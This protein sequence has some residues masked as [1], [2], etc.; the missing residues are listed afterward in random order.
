MVEHDGIWDGGNADLV[1]RN[2]TVALL[3]RGE[4]R[5]C[6]VTVVGD[7]IAGLAADAEGVIGPETTVIDAADQWV[8]PGFVDAHTH[9]DLHQTVE[10]AQHRIL[11]GGTTTLVTDLAEVVPRFGCEGFEAFRAAAADLAVDVRFT[12][13]PQPFGATLHEPGLPA[14]ERDGLSELLSDESVVGVGETEWIHLVGEAPPRPLLDLYDRAKARSKRIVGHGAGCR[15]EKLTSFAAYVDN[16]HEST[17][18]RDVFERLD[19][20]VHVVGRYGSIRDDLDA[21]TDAWPDVDACEVSLSTD[22]MWP[23]ELVEEGYMDAVV[24]E[25]IERGIEPL[26]A[27]RMAT[28]TPARHFRIDD[29][30]SIAPGNRADLVVLDEVADVDVTTVVSAGEPVVVDGEATERAAPQPAT[31]PDR[32]YEPLDIDLDPDLL[33]VPTSAV[34][35]DA[36]RAIEHERGLLTS[37]T[38][39]EPPREGGQFRSARDVHKAALVDVHPTA[40]RGSFTGFVTGL[41]LEQGA[42]ATSVTWEASGLLGVGGDDGDVFDAMERVVANGGGWAVVDDGSLVAELRTPVGGT[43]ADTPVDETAAD[44]ERLERALTDFGMTSDDP[45]IPIQTLTMPGVPALR[46]SFGGYV[47]VRRRAVL[48]LDPDE[49]A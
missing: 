49:R 31:Y 6:D 9:V 38:V 22:G 16:D 36:V 18:A 2:G 25:A 40:D 1:I 13:P 21:V 7:R 24:S 11:E 47:D 3:E 14:A 43:C 35:G 33:S 26:D 4:F 5:E 17:G 8:V 44:F 28:L 30:G 45:T 10:Q 23:R 20:G 37:A 29:R 15:D 32:M 41:G 42:V 34:D 46:M 48:G 19:R 39:V 12:I 27:I